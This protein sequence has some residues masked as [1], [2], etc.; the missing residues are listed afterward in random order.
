MKDGCKQAKGSTCHSMA[1]SQT[2]PG[3]KPATLLRNKR[4][5]T[6]QQMNIARECCKA[7][8][9]MLQGTP[10]TFRVTQT[11]THTHPSGHLPEAA[12]NRATC[13]APAGSASTSASRLLTAERLD[14][15]GLLLTT[16]KLHGV[17]EFEVDK[18][19]AEA[20]HS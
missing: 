20:L 15:R 9:S 19:L 3:C 17:S 14:M 13:H 2:Q 7:K 1:I 4:P 16:V 10:K 12:C 11:H 6:S 8:D 18:K 5:P